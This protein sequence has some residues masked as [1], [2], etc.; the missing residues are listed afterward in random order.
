VS[1]FDENRMQSLAQDLRTQ[2]RSAEPFPHVVIDNFLPSEYCEAI[3]SEFPGP[4]QIPWRRYKK[5]YGKKLAAHDDARFGEHI[6]SALRQLNSVACLRFLETLTGI[7]ALIPDSDFE[8]GG[9]HQIE[10]GGFLKVHLDSNT[11]PRLPLAR[12]INLLLYLNKDW[13]DAYHGHLE[14]WDKETSCCVCK[15]LPTFNRCVIFNTNDVSYHGHPDRL[16]CPPG[17]TR[18]SI[19]V[20]YYTHG[21]PAAD[22]ARD[23]GTIWRDRPSPRSASGAYANRLRRLT[24]AVKSPGK[25]LRRLAGDPR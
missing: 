7:G 24:S 9:L 23:H 15:V 6:Q 13:R 12:R 14:L 11:H 3:L 19:A 18:K 5:H 21:R 8:G 22:G 2:Y 25:L 10:R 16:E 17:T 4:G 1:I 20:Y